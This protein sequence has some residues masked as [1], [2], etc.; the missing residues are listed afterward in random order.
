MKSSEILGRWLKGPQSFPSIEIVEDFNC[1]YSRTHTLE[2]TTFA[3][4]SEFIDLLKQT[5]RQFLRDYALS[6]ILL[7]AEDEKTCIFGNSMVSISSI[8]IS[9]FRYNQKFPVSL[10][11]R[12]FENCPN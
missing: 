5:R 4:V 12:I 1:F 9:K 8:L 11:R 10:D 2:R 7:Y 6:S 3:V